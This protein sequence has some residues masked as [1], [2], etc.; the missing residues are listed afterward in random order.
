MTCVDGAE[1]RPKGD[2][3]SGAA[4]GAIAD[5]GCRGSGGLN[6]CN[7]MRAWR[8][9]GGGAGNRALR[10]LAPGVFVVLMSSYGTGHLP[11]LN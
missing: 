6:G 7:G 4:T 5:G 8:R 10:G 9:G 1:R 3:S 2:A 11:P